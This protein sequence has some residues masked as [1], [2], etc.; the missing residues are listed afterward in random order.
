M[1]GSVLA[2]DTVL[3][4]LWWA[5]GKWTPALT[6]NRSDRLLRLLT[7]K[8]HGA[9]RGDLFHAHIQASQEG[10]AHELGLSREWVNKLLA[11]LSA[12]GWIRTY[13]PRLPDG[14]YLPCF[15]RPGGQLKR[16]LCVLLRSRRPRPSRVNSP[17]PSLP[18]PPEV[19]EN[20]LHFWHK[21]KADLSRRLNGG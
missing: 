12:A 5:L 1:G 20:N 18:P 16:L 13:A 6:R 8:L 3:S 21:L 9:S 11:R 10:L 19:R 7:L 15:I 17:S 14:R 2:L 4:S